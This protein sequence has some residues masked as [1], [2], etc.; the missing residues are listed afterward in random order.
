MQYNNKFDI[1]YLV[2]FVTWYMNENMNKLI[3]RKGSNYL[4]ISSVRYL[5]LKLNLELELMPMLMLKRILSFDFY[6]KF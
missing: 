1:I 5:K 3:L 2:N 6:F 4:F